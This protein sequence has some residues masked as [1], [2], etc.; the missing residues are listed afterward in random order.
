MNDTMNPDFHK[1]NGM[2]LNLSSALTLKEC[3]RKDSLWTEYCSDSVELEPFQ[4]Q[5]NVDCCETR[6]TPYPNRS[7][8][9]FP[10]LRSDKFDKS[11]TVRIQP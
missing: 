2:N 10:S 11:V 6:G 5:R 9:K 8:P 1:L 4:H 7:F 3:G